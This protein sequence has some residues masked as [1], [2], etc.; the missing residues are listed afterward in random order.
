MKVKGREIW[1]AD[2]ETDPFDYD[3]IPKPFIWGLYNGTEYYEFTNTSSFIDFIRNRKAI[4]YA[5]NGGKFDWHFISPWFEHDSPLLVIAGRLARFKIGECEF[6][7]S[8]N[9]YAKPLEAFQKEKFDYNKMHYSVRHRYMDEIKS[10]LKSDCVNLFNLVTGFINKYGMHITAASA[11]MNY[12]TY[13]TENKKQKV[14]RSDGFF[15]E[16][17]KPYF[18]GGRV[19]C[20]EQGDITIDAQSADINSA[21]PTAM[22]EQHPYGLIYMADDGTPRKHMKNWGPMFFDIEC[23]SRGAFGYR[24]SQGTLYYPDDGKKRVYNV[25]GWELIAAIETDTVSELKILGYIE[26]S[27][28]KSFKKYISHFWNERKEIKNKIA[29]AYKKG[30]TEKANSL[31]HDSDFSKLMMNSLYG[32]FAANPLRYKENVLMNRDEFYSEYINDISADETWRDFREWVILQKPQDNSAKKF[33]NLATAA[34]ITGFVRAKLWRSICAS[35]RPFYCDTDS[36]TAVS[37]GKE[38]KLGTELGE[39]EIE[40]YYDRV[41]MGGK[42]LYGFHYRGKKMNDPAAWKLASKGARVTHGDIIKIGAGEMVVYKPLAPTFSVAKAQPTFL[43]REI[44]GTAEDSRIVPK[45]F[46]PQ[47][48]DVN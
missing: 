36:I 44:R 38:T 4:V 3:V 45:E 1:V 35:E 14:P 41:I 12:W 10:Y 13:K 23:I 5:H 25:T 39:W 8:I 28:L 17:F 46:D 20:F 30:D 16:T 18:F 29:K 7:D 42:K 40:H 47:Y 21:Y 11:A 15:Y 2:S 9:L 22:M 32:K 24:G 19:Q 37:F 48:C 43:R 34:S 27:E 33:F 31:K 6:R 26:F